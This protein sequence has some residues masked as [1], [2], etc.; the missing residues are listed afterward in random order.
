MELPKDPGKVRGSL[1]DYRR[2]LVNR[3]AEQ[4]VT[5]LAKEKGITPDA[6]RRWLKLVERTAKTA[7]TFESAFLSAADAREIESHGLDPFAEKAVLVP[8]IGKEEEPK[9]KGPKS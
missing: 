8:I 2:N 4:T 9:A 7:W 1:A 6:R 3:I 5:E